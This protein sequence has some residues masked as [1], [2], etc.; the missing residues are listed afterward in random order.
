MHHVIIATHTPEVCP[1][2]NAR[3][4]A[5]MLEIGPQIPAIGEKHNVQIVAGPFV[6]QEHTVVVVVETERS[7]DLDDFLNESR[8][9]QW[10]RLHILASRTMPEGMQEIEDAISLF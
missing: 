1:T 5:L 10:N 7:E 2:S 4:K 9:G 6:N 8:L 3:T